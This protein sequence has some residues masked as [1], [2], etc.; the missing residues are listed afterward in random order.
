MDKITVLI[1]DAPALLTTE[2]RHALSQQPDFRV[3]DCNPVD[4]LLVAIEVNLP[5]IVLLGS[6]LATLSGL[7]LGKKITCFFP[8]SKVMMLSPNPNDEELFEVIKTASVAY[9]N[10]NIAADELVRTIRRAYS[11]E[12]PI[13]NSLIA[14]TSVAKY[15]LNQFQDIASMVKATD[16]LIAPLNTLEK[17]ILT[18]AAGGI[19]ERR[20]ALTLKTS[21]QV[22]KNH[23][24]AIL[25]KL[26]TYDRVC[27]VT[28]SMQNTPLSVEQTNKDKVAAF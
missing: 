21:E 7:E 22:I 19:T 20:I 2:V 12:Y 15:V 25:R 16:H 23:I 11:G 8:N 1:I 3:V 6:D 9:L 5:D 14:R 26:I 28:L 17:E 24:S 13:N 4:D 27:G 10:K 18:C